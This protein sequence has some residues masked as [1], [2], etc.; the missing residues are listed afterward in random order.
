[1]QGPPGSEVALVVDRRG[2]ELTLPDPARASYEVK[3]VEGRLLEEGIG[4]V[5]IRVFAAATDSDAGA[6][7]SISS[8]PKAKG[9]RGWCWT[10][11]ATRAACSTRGS[12]SPTASSPTG[13][14]VKTVGK[15]GR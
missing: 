8:Q 13:L 11:G 9:L 10:C 12:A 1:M 3:A 14:I 5:K 2:R 7:C 4:Y 15:G 6:S